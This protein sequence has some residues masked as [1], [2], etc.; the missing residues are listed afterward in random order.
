MKISTPMIDHEILDLILLLA[1]GTNHPNQSSR[2]ILSYK[3]ISNALK[4][5][6][7]YVQKIVNMYLR[8]DLSFM[9]MKRG[10]SC[11]LMKRHIEY[12]INPA[13]LNQWAG[14]S[15]IERSKMFHRRFPEITISRSHLGR[16]YHNHGIK[17]K[18]VR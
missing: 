5:S 3:A 4:I 13:T 2:R 15:L 1:F 11:K 12:L 10:H 9:N 17:F 16:I 14:L 6:S 7:Y 8:N 18:V